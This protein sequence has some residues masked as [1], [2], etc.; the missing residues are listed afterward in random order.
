MVSSAAYLSHWLTLAYLTPSS[1]VL[2]CYP[3]MSITVW[4]EVS[5]M[6]YCIYAHPDVFF[7]KTVKFFV[8]FWFYGIFPIHSSVA[9]T[10][11]CNNVHHI[12]SNFF[13]S[14]E[15]YCNVSRT[16]F[17][18]A[19]LRPHCI[20]CMHCMRTVV[21]GKNLGDKIYQKNGR[22]SATYVKCL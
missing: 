5:P 2:P 22:N 1:T 12:G 7:P 18:L 15:P 11:I 4:V 17:M 6:L 3:S 10:H 8:I 16:R 19:G 9:V 13:H 20:Q 21:Y 14:R